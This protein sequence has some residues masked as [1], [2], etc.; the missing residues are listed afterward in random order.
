MMA[1][2]FYFN[3]LV[4]LS[5]NVIKIVKSGIKYFVRLSFVPKL[6]RNRNSR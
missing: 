3:F 6:L 4:G 1:E 5:K 2:K